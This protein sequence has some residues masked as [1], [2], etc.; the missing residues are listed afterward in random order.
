MLGCALSMAFLT[1]IEEDLGSLRG[2]INELI[3]RHHAKSEAP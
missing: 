2:E 3:A 1:Y